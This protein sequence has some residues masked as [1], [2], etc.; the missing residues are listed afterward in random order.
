[1]RHDIE[2]IKYKNGF[3]GFTM[4][5]IWT[6]VLALAVVAL[7]IWYYAFRNLDYFKKR[8]IP[9]VPPVPLFGNMGG[10]VFR[11]KTFSETILEAY[12][13]NPEAKYVGFFDFGSPVIFVRDPELIKTITIKSFD[14]FPDHK[15]LSEEISD[16]LFKQNLFGLNG[17]R[18]REMR[19]LLSPTFTSSKMKILFKLMK[20]CTSNFVDH[21]KTR[22]AKSG[23]FEMR[24]AL[25]RYTN[26]V[27]MT[28]AF[29]ISVNSLEDP[30]NDF[31]V[32]GREATNFTGARSLKLFFRRSFPTLANIVDVKLWSDKI[33]NFYENIVKT[34]IAAR[35]ARGIVRPDMLQLMMQA[36]DKSETL[37]LTDDDMAAHAFTFYFGGFDSV[38]LLMCC[39]IHEIAVHPDVHEKLQA[40]VD[41]VS[42]ECG[43]VVSYEALH[44]M[45]YLDNVVNET[46]RL[47][48]PAV[49][50]DRLC[51]QSFELPPAQPG[52][53]P[54]LV[55][56]GVSI[57]LPFAAIHK[58]AKYY[59]NPEEFDPD[60]FGDEGK[61]K[62]DPATFLPFGSGPRLCIGNRFALMET[63]LVIFE[64]LA[65]FDITACSK[66]INPIRLSRSSFVPNIEGGVWLKLERRNQREFESST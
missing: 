15:M 52:L 21:L 56:P 34:T 38:A 6:I 47:H 62:I 9:Y 41:Q 50:T 20:D 53:K 49:T 57:W 24:D 31:Y 18:W 63:K 43:G 22:N 8:G 11:T 32:T 46:L 36:R 2:V 54:F 3:V 27:I 55:E 12:K 30:D 59:E 51:R 33:V 65:N 44:A 58:D 16:K 7:T 28:S 39:A 25:T 48:S 23:E 1:M 37:K 45:P 5:E 10:M 40:E 42:E 60:R 14:N 26:D 61:S 64:L 4:S 29:G 19:A 13:F 66:T 17:Q 35:D